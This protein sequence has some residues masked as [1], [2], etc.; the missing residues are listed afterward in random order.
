VGTYLHGPVLARNPELADLLLAWA[1]D[2]DTL[3]TLDDSTENALRDERLAST[4]TR[5]RRFGR[6]SG[7]VSGRRSRSRP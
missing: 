5:S 4:T 6:R 1:L 7:S 3:E 2:I